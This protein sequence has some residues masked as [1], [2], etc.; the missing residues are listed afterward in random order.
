[1]C[2]SFVLNELN[3]EKAQELLVG[4]NKTVKRTAT[5]I[6]KSKKTSSSNTQK[7]L[8]IALARSLDTEQVKIGN[9]IENRV[10]V[11]GSYLYN[12]SHAPTFDVQRLT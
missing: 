12:D 2:H 8:C 11:S 5:R 3:L 4:M 7:L 6:Q 10:F 1:V 9:V